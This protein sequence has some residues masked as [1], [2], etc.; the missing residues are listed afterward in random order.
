MFEYCR[1]ISRYCAYLVLTWSLK[2]AVLE[3]G[4]VVLVFPLPVLMVMLLVAV[5]LFLR[6]LALFRYNL[7]ELRRQY[8]LVGKL[9]YTLL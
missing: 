1:V 3:V 5:L 2:M 4:R 8:G 7:I 9:N 6:Q